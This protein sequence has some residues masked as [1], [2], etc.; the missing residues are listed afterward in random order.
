MADLIIFTIWKLTIVHVNNS[1][2]SPRG[3]R[4]NLTCVVNFGLDKINGKIERYCLR[5]TFEGASFNSNRK[6]DPVG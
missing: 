1:Q 4:Y 3:K 5:I 2:L 6:M